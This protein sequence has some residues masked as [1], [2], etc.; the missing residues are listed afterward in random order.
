MFKEDAKKFR[1]IFRMGK[2]Y[3]ILKGTLKVAN[4][5]FNPIPETVF[6]FVPID[7]LGLHV[8][9]K[10]LVDVIGVVQNVSPT[11]S[12]RRKINDEMIPKRDI[13]IADES[14]KIVAV[15]LWNDHAT[16]LGQEL[17]D[18]ADKSPVVAIKSIKVGDFPGMVQCVSLKN[19]LNIGVSLSAIS[20]TVGR[21]TL[22]SVG[23]GMSPSPVSGGRSMYTDR[24]TNNPSLGEDKPIFFN[25]KAYIG[26]IRPD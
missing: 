1:D 25:I 5:R 9:G 3:Y 17:L 13:T 10:D 24:I 12:I 20:K 22:A 16:T 19:R 26:L 23:A 7:Q 14:K 4:K 18:M 8:N 2:V 11:T 6:N 15:P 21:P